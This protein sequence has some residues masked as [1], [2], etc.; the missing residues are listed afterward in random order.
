MQSISNSVAYLLFRWSIRWS[1]FGDGKK[2][3]SSPYSVPC[4]PAV[5]NSWHIPTNN[6]FTSGCGVQE[7]LKEEEKR[8]KKTIIKEEEKNPHLLPAHHRKCSLSSRLCKSALMIMQRPKNA[9]SANSWPGLTEDHEESSDLSNI[10]GNY[11][12]VSTVCVCVLMGNAAR[13]LF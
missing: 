3:S 5:L 12:Y 10:F 11:W 8:K 9:R 4:L 7:S 2:C 1:V 6:R 13:N